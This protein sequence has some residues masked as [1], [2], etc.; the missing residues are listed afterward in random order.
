MHGKNQ[1]LEDFLDLLEVEA[2]KGEPAYPLN[3]VISEL[4]KKHGKK[5]L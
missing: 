2:H 5:L 4:E 3:D 1:P